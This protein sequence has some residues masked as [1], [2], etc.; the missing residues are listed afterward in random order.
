MTHSSLPRLPDQIHFSTAINV[1]EIRSEREWTI[2]VVQ[3]DQSVVRTVYPAEPE[4]R[5]H[6]LSP[7]YSHLFLGRTTKASP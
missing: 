6:I 3:D 5:H 7:L 2:N 4:S 1:R